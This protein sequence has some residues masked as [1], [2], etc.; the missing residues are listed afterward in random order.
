M[1]QKISRNSPRPGRPDEPVVLDNW[2]ARTE[3][4]LA[5][6]QA[7]R[8][9]WVDLATVAVAFRPVVQELGGLTKRWPAELAR[10]AGEL[11][12]S[13]PGTHRLAWADGPRVHRPPYADT[14]DQAIRDADAIE[15]AALDNTAPCVRPLLTDLSRHLVD[16]PRVRALGRVLGRPRPRRPPAAP[17]TSAEARRQYL[18]VAARLMRTRAHLMRPGLF[19]R[20]DVAGAALQDAVTRFRQGWMDMHGVLVRCAGDEAGALAAVEKRR[21]NLLEDLGLLAGLL[22]ARRPAR[23]ARVRK[24]R[25]V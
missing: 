15:R 17:P 8:A 5:R 1:M 7:L 21:E 19:V 10:R 25:G 16:S 13:W 23:K 4:A 18:A 11:P 20:R 24:E 9:R 14:V 2:R 12:T 3:Q 22:P 6:D